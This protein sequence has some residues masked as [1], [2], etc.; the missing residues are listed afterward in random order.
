MLRKA[1]AAKNEHDVYS[2]MSTAITAF[3]KDLTPKFKRVI[4]DVRNAS[5]TE[6]AKKLKA[7]L[8]AR[9]ASIRSMGFRTAEPKIGGFAFDK[10]NPAAVKWVEEHAADTIDGI[11][12]TTRENIKDLVEQEFQGTFDVDELTDR[13]AELIGNSERAEMIARTETMRASNEGQQEAWD[14]AVEEGLL[15][16]NEQQE[17]IVTPDDRLC[18]ECEPFDTATAELGGTFEAEGTESDGPPL[19]PR[20]RCTLGLKL[21]S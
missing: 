4:E 12:E 10:S 18:P 17:W 1:V 9:H 5:G 14:Q 16:G 6:S 19:H 13:I 15:T 8:Q 21:G 11:S 7:R 20:C 2:I 3:E